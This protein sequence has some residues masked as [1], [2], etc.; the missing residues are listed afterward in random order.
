MTN[1]TS[2]TDLDPQ[3]LR[4]YLDELSSQGFEGEIGADLANRLIAATDNSIYQVEPFAVLYP[5][6]AEDVTLAMR[7]AA[8]GSFAPIPLSPRGG[9]TGTNGQSLTSGIVIDLSR[10]LNRILDFNQDALLVT[11]EPGV[12]LDQLNAFLATLGYF[13]PPNVSTATR[14]TLGGMLATDASGKGSRIYGKTSDYIH[15]MDVVL[16]DGSEFRVEHMDVEDAHAVA[17]EDTTIGRAIAQVISTVGTWQKRI[18]D[19]FPRMNRGLTGYNL[20]KVWDPFKGLDLYRVLAGSEGTLAIT[21]SITFRVIPIPRY[22]ALAVVRYS[23]FAETL[24]DVQRLLKAEPLAVEVLD[25]KVLG[26]ARTD[27]VWSTIQSIL[28]TETDQPVNGMSFVEFIA[29]SPRDLDG[30]LSQFRRLMGGYQPAGVIDSQI[31]TDANAIKQLW[32]LRE[33]SVGLAGKMAGPR[34]GVA[35]VED[36]AVPPERLVGFVQEFRGILDSH[37]LTYAMYGHADVG[38]LHVRPA[39]NMRDPVDAARIRPI[40]D[41]V[42]NLVKKY[43]GLLWGEHGRGFRGEYSP[44]FFGHELYPELCKIKA[45]FDPLNILN[46][47]KLAS[48]M[49]D[50]PVTPIDAPVLRG[51]I[52]AAISADRAAPVEKSLACNG[53]GIC[54][55]WDAAETMCPSYKATRDRVQSPKGRATL[56]REWARRQTEADKTG[57]QVALREIE[58]SVKSSLSTCLSCKACATACPIQVDIPT[59]KARFLETYYRTRRRKRRDLVVAQLETFAMIAQGFPRL[60]NLVAMNP[61]ARMV[62]SAVGLVDLPAFSTT[63][64]LPSRTFSL[65]KLKNLEPQVK[66]QTVILVPDTFTGAFDHETQTV[67]HRLLSQLGYDV[68]LAPLHANGKP[69]HILGMLGKFA[70]IAKAARERHQAYAE[71]GVSVVGVEPVAVLMNRAE[72]CDSANA[73]PNTAVR[74]IDE[75]LCDE[76][77]AGRLKLQTGIDGSKFTLL[78]HCTER[79]LSPMATARW[80][81]IFQAFGLSVNQPRVGCCG[82]AGVFGHER[83]NRATSLKLYDMSWRDTVADAAPGVVLGTGFSCRCQAERAGKVDIRHP[84]SALLDHLIAQIAIG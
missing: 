68:H 50:T 37:G 83:E 20:Q 26:V 44:L 51:A 12:V 5:K 72:Y 43:G 14:A 31:V 71:A 66:A 39:L 69:L 78:L 21:K 48:P 27:I 52:D 74:T 10:H 55:S 42:A 6:R 13:F 3:R 65:V 15:S 59:M 62:M 58:A 63:R 80:A 7:L 64:R 2:G 22:R 38:C 35:F 25:D 54:F 46:P 4:G 32:N 1:A 76:M 28:K 34:Q 40:S 45:A 57:D 84:V 18:D 56:L 75:F 11:V 36:C 49:P 41:A 47:G 77:D 29:H 81:R 16:A 60:A 79:S 53:N 67:F 23:S 8:A 73:G 82:M 9:G 24:A 70:P 30:H 19:V 17:Q 61:L 33:K